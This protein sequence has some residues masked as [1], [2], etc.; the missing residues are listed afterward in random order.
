MAKKNSKS[1]V[2]CIGPWFPVLSVVEGFADGGA[3]EADDGEVPA[4]LEFSF[5]T[6]T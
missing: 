6:M 2:V 4:N 1:S 5:L 3:V